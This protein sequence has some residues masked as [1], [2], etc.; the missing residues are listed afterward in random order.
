MSN[1]SEQSMLLESSVHH[2]A[3][4]VPLFNYRCVLGPTNHS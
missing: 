2:R 1:L 3:Q 4:P